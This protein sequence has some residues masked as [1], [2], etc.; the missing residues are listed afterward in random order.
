M[1][2]WP[3]KRLL[4]KNLYKLKGPANMANVAANELS[5]L[6]GILPRELVQ[7][8]REHSDI[9]S[10]S[11]DGNAAFADASRLWHAARAIRPQSLTIK[12][13]L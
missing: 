2:S 9:V 8:A 5:Q 7:I 11:R 3:P 10:I 1:L 6:L 13:R 4:K 12:R